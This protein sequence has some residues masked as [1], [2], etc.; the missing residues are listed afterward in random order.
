MPK[1]NG[2][3][4]QKYEKILGSP[5]PRPFP[6]WG[7]GYPS[8]RLIPLDACGTSTP[9]IL[10]S[11]VRHC[12]FICGS[13]NLGVEQSVLCCACLSQNTFEQYLF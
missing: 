4:N 6:Q 12:L 11:W 13:L 8:P 10:K 7:G 1:N 2:I 9:P 3:F 5:L